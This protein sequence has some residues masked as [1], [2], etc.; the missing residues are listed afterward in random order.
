MP[1]LAIVK[2]RDN[3][4]NAFFVASPNIQATTKTGDRF[5]P[6]VTIA[7]STILTPNAPEEIGS[8]ATTREQDN[9]GEIF[10]IG[11]SQSGPPA[12]RTKRFTEAFQP[13]LEDSDQV[14]RANATLDRH[15]TE[16]SAGLLVTSNATFVDLVTFTR[17]ATYSAVRKQITGTPVAPITVSNL[18]APPTTSRPDGLIV[19]QNPAEGVLEAFALGN[20]P[21]TGFRTVFRNKQTSPGVWSTNWTKFVPSDTVPGPI[22]RGGQ[23]VS[24]AVGAGR[25]NRLDVFALARLAGG[26][27]AVVHARPGA[28]SWTRVAP[29]SVPAA[30]K[31]AATGG[32]TVA[33]IVGGVVPVA[34]ARLAVFVTTREGS[35]VRVHTAIQATPDTSDFANWQTLPDTIASAPADAI[36]VAVD[37]STTT[38]VDVLVGSGANLFHSVQS[39]SGFSQWRLI[40][41]QASAAGG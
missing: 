8:V 37:P 41:A 40:P 23:I 4:L 25:D 6:R 33:R 22:P 16:V 9:T 29:A 21:A 2:G 19:R 11:R 38:F 14:T 27:L 28:P 13:P 3:R 26:E 32:L 35:T 1:R 20:D 15:T 5:G 12:V 24:F 18:G 34:G 7:N 10:V 39:A 30:I 17:D 31:T 36:S